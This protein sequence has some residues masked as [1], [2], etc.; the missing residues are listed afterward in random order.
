LT[1]L[2]GTNP[3]SALQEYRAFFAHY[4]NP[5]D[6]QLFEYKVENKAL[7]SRFQ[8]LNPALI[9]PLIGMEGLF[10]LIVVGHKVLGEEYTHEEI[11]LLDRLM[12]FASIS[13]QNNIYYNS[14]V[15]DYKTRLYNHS[16]FI[17]RLQEEVA[18]VRRYGNAFSILAIDVDFFKLINDRHGHLAGDKALFQLAR[19]LEESLREED[20]LSRFGGEEF[21]VLLVES[22]LPAAA[23]VA[24]RI[25]SDVENLRIDYEDISIRITVSIGV[26]HVNG[27]RLGSEDNLIDQ[28][29]NA[30]Y[31]SK[32]SGRNR[33]S[34]YNPGFLF[35]AEQIRHPEN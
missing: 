4:P 29:D 33:V 15:T 13:L 9:V 31:I 12:K 25:R 8:P 35:K 1:T 21:F 32:N 7:A 2:D 24:E 3:G 20:V 26:N 34:I 6:F 23:H 11:L 22:T 5:I 16:Y 19:T 30:L 14:A 18:K 17:R 28:A 27:S 10:G